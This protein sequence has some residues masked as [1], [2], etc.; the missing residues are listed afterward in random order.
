MK[1]THKEET[2]KKDFVLL[3]P[4]LLHDTV[5]II[6]IIILVQAKSLSFHLVLHHIYL[7]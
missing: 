2:R 6:I 1:G 7:I 4:S 3:L 5:I